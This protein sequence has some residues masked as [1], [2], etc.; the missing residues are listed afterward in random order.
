MP[1]G[2]PNMKNEVIK[3]RFTNTSIRQSLVNKHDDIDNAKA[4]L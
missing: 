3:K 2:A 1:P 4:G